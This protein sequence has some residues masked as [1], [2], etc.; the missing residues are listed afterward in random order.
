MGE[1]QEEYGGWRIW[2][3]ANCGAHPEYGFAEHRYDGC[4]PAF[5]GR[6]ALNESR[7]GETGSTGTDKG[8]YEGRRRK[9][10]GDTTEIARGQYLY[11]ALRELRYTDDRPGIRATVWE[12]A[13]VRESVKGDDVIKSN[14]TALI[15]AG[16]LL[17][18]VIVGCMTLLILNGKST[19]DIRALLNTVMNFVSILLGGGAMVFA[20]QANAS[21]GQAAQQ[22]NG[23]LDARIRSAVTAAL[24]DSQRGSGVPPYRS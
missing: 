21:A 6:D 11:D 8:E 9:H 5:D 16:T 13:M 24:E 22:T 19:E 12:S 23:E 17:A 10:E 4:F 20:R 1:I 15:A 3:G 14:M 2:A 18:A 7:A